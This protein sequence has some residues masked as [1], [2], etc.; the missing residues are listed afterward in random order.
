[1]IPNWLEREQL[2]FLDYGTYITM[3]ILTFTIVAKSICNDNQ[4]GG[5]TSK[6]LA[7]LAAPCLVLEF[8]YVSIRSLYKALGCIRLRPPYLPCTKTQP[9]TAITSGSDNG[10]TRTANIFNP[11]TSKTF[12][13]KSSQELSLHLLLHLPIYILHK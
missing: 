3:A 11:I 5:A 2:R 10:L 7:C 12:N 1:V 6:C 13:L 4:V 8:V 9:I